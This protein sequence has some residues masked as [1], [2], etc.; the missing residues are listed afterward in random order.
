MSNAKYLELQA[1]EIFG[2]EWTELTK[3]QKAELKFYLTQMIINN[4]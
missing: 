2:K 4:Y 3:D 1:T